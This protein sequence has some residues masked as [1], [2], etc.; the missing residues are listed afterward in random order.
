MVEGEEESVVEEDRRKHKKAL[1]PR[2]LNKPSPPLPSGEVRGELNKFSSSGEVRE[3]VSKFSSSEGVRGEVSKLK[4]QGVRKL[5]KKVVKR[6]GMGGGVKGK[7]K[8]IPSELQQKQ[9]REGEEQVME[10][11]EPLHSTVLLSITTL[12]QPSKTTNKQIP[13]TTNEMEEEK[14]EHEKLV[15]EE[16][17]IGGS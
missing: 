16:D 14:E 13:H 1:K 7:K 15:S 4:K 5:V 2:P 10:E 6:K 12:H 9:K 11:K 3:E 8:S 17:L